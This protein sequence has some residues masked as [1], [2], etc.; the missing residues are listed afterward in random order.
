M[1]EGCKGKLW[2]ED[3]EVSKEV[4]RGENFLVTLRGILEGRGFCLGKTREI[5]CGTVKHTV[6]RVQ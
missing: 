6:F 4:C 1:N 5:C 2:T 3:A